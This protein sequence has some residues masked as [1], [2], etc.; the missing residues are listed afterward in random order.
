MTTSK[1]FIYPLVNYECN[2]AK[3]EIA[4]NLIVELLKDS[5][6][7]PKFDDKEFA[8]F[9]VKLYI[10]IKV[11]KFGEKAQPIKKLRMKYVFDETTTAF[12]KD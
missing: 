9:L 3:L 5:A 1:A 2:A 7:N 4:K 11:A 12:V 6:K 8:A 10:D